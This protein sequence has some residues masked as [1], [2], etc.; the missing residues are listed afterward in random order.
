MPDNQP[1][2]LSKQLLASTASIALVAML[3]TGGYAQ[4]PQAP[5]VASGSIA[6]TRQGQ[7][8]VV[9][10]GSEKGIID[11]RSFSIGSGEAVR[12]DQPGRSSVTL[13]RVTGTEQ[14][15][16]DGNLSANGQVWL[17]N[18]NGVM[19]GPGGQVNVGGL[20]ATT[21]RID[22]QE[23]LRSGRALIDQIPKDAGVINAGSI[24]AGDGG[25]AALAAAAVENK[26]V[27]QA[28]TGTVA[29]GAGKAM[30][31]DF[32]GDRFITFQVTQPLDKAP[33]GADALITNGGT[34]SAPGGVVVLSARAAK[35]VL[36]RVINLNGYAVA[37][38]ITERNGVIVIDGGE[39]GRVDVSGKLIAAGGSTLSG[40]SVDLKG[41][42]VAVSGR[43]ILDASGGVVSEIIEVTPDGRFRSETMRIRTDGS[44]YNVPQPP[45]AG[46]AVS[47][48]A[49]QIT[50][51]ADVRIK[52][53]GADSG[54][55][56][57]LAADQINQSGTLDASGDKGGEIIASA[58]GII[59][60]GAMVADGI[61]RDGGAITVQAK[62][63]FIATLGARLQADS[64]RGSGGQVR[65]I[66]TNTG[67]VDGAVTAR[68][69]TSG[70]QTARSESGRGGAVD[71]IGQDILLVAATL[72]TSGGSGG[73]TIRVGGD[74][75]GKG[76][77][78]H[79]KT[80]LSTGTAVLK[81]S[82]TK[83]GDGGVIVA[84][85]DE[86][87]RLGS[88]VEAKGAGGGVGGR[89]EISSK[90]VLNF[91]GTVNAATLLL[92]P[93]NIT[94][95]DDATLGTSIQSATLTDPGSGGAGY[96]SIIKVLPNGNIVVTSPNDTAGSLTNRGAAY[97]F[98][99]AN[100]G[101]ISTLT[102]SSSGDFVSSGGVT[103]L[104]N[105]N[106]VISSPNWKNGVFSNAGAVTWG[107]KTDGVSGPV[108]DLNS[109]IGSRTGDQVGSGG[110]T[111]LSDG[112]YVVKSPNWANGSATA[113]GAVTWGS[114]TA[115]VKGVVSADNSLVGSRANDQVG[116]G[117]GTVT[118]AGGVVALS[119]GGYVV[120]SP[121]WSNGTMSRA[122]AVTFG[123]AG[124]VR[125]PVSADNS[126]IGSRTNDVV[127]SGGMT[128]LTNG[129]YVVKS[130]NWAN[131]TAAAA[132][133]VT[134]GSGTGGVTGPV[135]EGNSL[136]GSRTGDQVGSGG[137]VSGAGGV[138]ALSGGGYVVVSPNWSNGAMTR[139]GAVTF[140]GGAGGVKGP[141]SEDNSLI[142]SRSNDQVG[143][144]GITVLTNGNYVV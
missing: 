104:T 6:V 132:G 74:W 102:G 5:T 135:S 52:A 99:A 83:I 138:I 90:G 117:N 34:L 28:R 136:I 124:G 20:L 139:A 17:S 11:W 4:S 3:V 85:S 93:K 30:T 25:Y 45:R 42:S 95:G 19:I 57:S 23:F 87:T 24:L 100:G 75:Q 50:I 8:T 32:V 71:V 106:Y 127:G 77:L 10:Q 64:L 36:D 86:K 55:R 56:I 2:S 122:G 101:L 76:A 107:S 119:G 37:T 62:T 121:S 134:W 130:P 91:S 65:V 97:L 123:A 67:A 31:I 125:G 60:S 98:N 82:A 68:V 118:G 39:S 16:L 53:A 73:G 89:V 92:D 141:I 66:G 59:H 109:L 112:N 18:P 27:I 126:L 111:I 54:G 22:A 49:Q 63:N 41:E 94:I 13:N 51:G 88:K 131:G 69:F 38:S 120:V 70:S 7:T 144:G 108:S 81:A 47:L 14:S 128:V 143:S 35:G 115:G 44:M 26:G 96:G 43:A 80:V 46:G 40:G 129:N 79:A 110:I 137:T 29:A 116:S 12:F 113:A 33:S 21:G 58:Q 84:W 105:G 9:T 140:G 142:G 114:G 78:T 48:N 61:N 72:D 1:V 15:R 103:V 133:A